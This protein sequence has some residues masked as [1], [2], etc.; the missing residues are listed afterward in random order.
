M[1]KR[2]IK[3]PEHGLNGD[4]YQYN[5]DVYR[6][7]DLMIATQIAFNKWLEGFNN[8]RHECTLRHIEAGRF[9]V[10]TDEG[11]VIEDGIGYFGPANM[12]AI[13]TVQDSQPVEYQQMLA[14]MEA[15]CKA[16]NPNVRR[17]K[18]TGRVMFSEQAM[19]QMPSW[20]GET[21]ISHADPYLSADREIANLQ[22]Q[23][24]GL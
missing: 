2:Y 10:Q 18:R 1:S 13:E 5:G 4:F 24:A 7:D 9:E 20:Y 11:L 22:M 12:F 8:L 3:L 23:W 21:Y 16:D 17:S 6:A 15:A 19:R 14:T